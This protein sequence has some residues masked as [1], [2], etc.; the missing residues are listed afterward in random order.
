VVRRPLLVGATA[1]LVSRLLLAVPSDLYARVGVGSGGR[2]PPGSFASWLEMPLTQTDYLRHF[3]LATWWIGAILGAVLLARRG[4][5]KSDVLCGLL[6]GIPAGLAGSATFACLLTGLD[7]LPRLVWHALNGTVSGMAGTSAAWLWTGVW[8]LVAVVCWSLL[9]AVAGLVL[10]S[11]G[12]AG[13]RLL[14]GVG[15]SLSWF[16]RLFGLKRTAAFFAV[17]G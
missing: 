7:W 1:G 17:Q 15:E 9:G 14:T 4:D 12:R 13:T 8:I 5:R 10:G 16:F 11:A 6:I 2:V 3:V